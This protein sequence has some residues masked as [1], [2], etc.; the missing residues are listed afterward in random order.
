MEVHHIQPPEKIFSVDPLEIGHANDGRCFLMEFGGQLLI[1]VKL[2][3]LVRVLKF[4]ATSDELVC[5]KTINNYAIFI[6][7]QRCL[8]VCAD[9]FPSIEANCVYYTKHRGSSARICR[10]NLNDDK[11]EMISKA[12]EFVKH[13]KQFVLAADRPFTIVQLLSSYTINVRDSE[14][15]LQQ[16]T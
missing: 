6:G 14:L 16:V 15:A 1:I 4:E 9:R 5:L 11:R 12:D 3:R 10:Y 13:D 2:Q 7:H 8:A